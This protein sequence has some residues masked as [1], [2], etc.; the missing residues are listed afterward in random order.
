[1]APT[2]RLELGPI[3]DQLSEG[4]L[5][6]LGAVFADVEAVFLP[7]A[8]DAISDGALVAAFPHAQCVLLGRQITSAQYG[9]L[10]ASAAASRCLD[11]TEEVCEHLRESGLRELGKICGDVEA[12]FCPRSVRP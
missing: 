8:C 6:E 1:M 12:V 4:G 5:A 9:E 11:L 7:P 2:E 10:L 3:C